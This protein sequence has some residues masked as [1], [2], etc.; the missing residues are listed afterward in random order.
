MFHQGWLNRT[1]FT[2]ESLSGR[3][4]HLQVSAVSPVSAIGVSIMYD[5]GVSYSDL[6][7]PACLHVFSPSRLDSDGVPRL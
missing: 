7:T 4:H 5:L 6:T 1:G 2:L 3:W